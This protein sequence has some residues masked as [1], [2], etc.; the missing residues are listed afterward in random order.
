MLDDDDALA[1]QLPGIRNSPGARREHLRRAMTVE[2]HA[3]VARQP[4]TSRRVE[5]PDDGWRRSATANQRPLPNR[6][7]EHGRC[8]IRRAN[9]PSTRR[10][11]RRTNSSNAEPTDRSTN[12][13]AT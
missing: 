10:A 12:E 7:T 9:R 11:N 8:S 6:T 5:G 3:P 13:S 2:I 1:E 4:P